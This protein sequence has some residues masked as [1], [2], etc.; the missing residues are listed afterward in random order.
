MSKKNKAKHQTKAT[1]A[2]TPVR[3]G[4]KTASYS[5][6]NSMTNW[7]II[8]VLVLPVLISSEA[9]DPSLSVRYIFLGIFMLLFILFF[10]LARKT[11][12]ISFANSRLLKMVFITGLAYC[13]W[14]IIAASAAVNVIPA[15]YEIARQLLNILLLW[16]IMQVTANEESQLL[17]LCR[18]IV[19]S[20]IIQSFAGITQYYDIAFTDIPGANAK[21]YGLMANRNLFGSAQAL[22]LPYVLLVLYKSTNWWRYV[23]GVAILG[24]IIS[25]I[26]SQ[27]RSAWLATAAIIIVSLVLVIIYSPVNRK[28]WI[29]ASAIG[30]VV[31][32]AIAYLFIATGKDELSSS[33]TQ[34]AGSLV[35]ASSDTANSSTNI[36]E[37]IKIWKKTMLV[38]KDHPVTGTG[39][40]NWKIVVPSYGTTGM[41]WAGGMYV[42]DR[43][44]NVYLQTASETG[45][46]GAILYV[47]LWAF[48]VAMGI[49]VLLRPQPEDRKIIVILMLAGLAAFAIDNLFSFSPERIEH[50]LYVLLMAGIIGGC[51][52]RS[53]DDNAADKKIPLPNK[54]K[55]AFIF[56]TAI[57]VMLGFSKYFFEVHMNYA[58]AY[59][60]AGRW[61]DELEEVRK[62]K[63]AFVNID[64]N[65][66]PLEI[67][68]SMAYRE[69]KNY[70][71]ALDEINKAN[72][73]NP[74]SPL[75]YNNWGTVYTN[76]QKFDTAIVLYK[77]AMQLAPEYDVVM[78]NLALNYFYAGKYAESLDWFGKVDIK[79]DQ[80]MRD[81]MNQAKQKLSR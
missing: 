3:T 77:Q 48:V 10:Y 73:I 30:V 71:A 40:G 45:I 35:N 74:N 65:G 4:K 18:A 42:P 76:M 63:S 23:S 66:Y 2:A 32:I 75:I 78:K 64:P 57:N 60:N 36:S 12:V 56:I 17:K 33:L 43:V 15:Y 68:S 62:G 50:T 47:A 26:L 79:G 51:Y 20:S 39:P 61:A 6:L 55:A 25:V 31:S 13:G 59:E 70:P 14:S 58:K 46:P 80:A 34:R 16:L 38:I 54:W 21:P 67:R 53:L 24:I 5:G 7:F 69:M 22:L 29:K 11:S 72:R 52:Y 41:S 8:L 28:G 19:I 81:I 37:R 9:M 1:V 27:T 44:H 49:K